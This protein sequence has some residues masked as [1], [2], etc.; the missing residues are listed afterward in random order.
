MVSRSNSRTHFDVLGVPRAFHL[1]DKDLESRYLEQSKKWH[2]DR[3]AKA[4]P[5]E[6]LEALT[7]TTEL[8]DAYK[9]LKDKRKRAE[10]L[11]KVEGLDVG[12]EKGMAVDPDLLME[13]LELNEQ[14]AEARAAGDVKRVEQLSAGV[15]RDHEQAWQ[16]ADE[17][18]TA[19][20]AG[21]R[22]LLQE[23]AQQLILMRYHARFF[24]AVEAFEE[25]GMT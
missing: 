4:T 14:L 1:D 23:I 6:R 12:K 18:F 13:V 7:R 16:K 17:G 19:Y 8:N 5:K 25:Q 10:Y 24:E 20:E 15:K 22:S 21:D 2:P 9:I 11:L 3:F